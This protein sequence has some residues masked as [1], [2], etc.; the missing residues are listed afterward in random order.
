[1]DIL[2]HHLESIEGTGLSHLYLSRE[3]HRQILSHDSIRCREECQDV[4][5]EVLLVFVQLLPVMQVL[6]QV[7]FFWSPE[8]SH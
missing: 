2:H 7:D 4:L 5:D 1:M 8:G 6:H 3:L